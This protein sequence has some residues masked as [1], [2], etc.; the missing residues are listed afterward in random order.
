MT[1]KSNFQVINPPN[2]LARKVPRSGGPDLE[3]IVNNAE[4]AL[5]ELKVEYDQ[6]IRDDLERMETALR[7]AEES[8]EKSEASIKAIYDTG[9]DIKGHG[10][11]FEFP[12]LG[13]IADSLCSLITDAKVSVAQQL[14]L[15]RLHVDA[16][17]VVVNESVDGAGGDQGKELIAMLRTAV[18]RV[19]N[20]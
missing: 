9:Y 8:P 14:Q 2:K 1:A 13:M 10:A 12:L 15:V 20:A 4:S 18:D 5:R 7:D 6:W 17:R 19:A 11:T 3:T 16:M